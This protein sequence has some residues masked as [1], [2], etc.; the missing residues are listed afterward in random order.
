[1]L[2]VQSLRHPARPI[3]LI[4]A[5]GA[6][7]IHLA[8]IALALSSIQ[9]DVATELGAPA[10]EI[11]VE[12]ASPRLETS[13]LPVGPD[14]Q[15]AAASPANVEQKAAIEQRDLPRAQ[16]VET[17]DPDR[18]VTPNETKKPRDEPK[19][20]AVQAAP[21]AP[22]VAADET[23]IP[24][25]AAAIEAPRSTAPAL[26]T[27]DS[28]RRERQTWQK[29]LAA[30]FNKYKRYPSDRATERAEVVVRFVLDRLGR[31][32]SSRIVHGSGDVAFDDAALGMLQ[33]ANPVPPPPPLVADEGLTFTMPVI[34]YVKG[35]EADASDHNPR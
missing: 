28:A 25:V 20:E 17:D 9:P 11:G 29:E 10:I 34:F 13:D 33:R 35:G 2:A 5:F 27:G 18:A 7:A 19:V 15:A 24:R 21:S 32:V 22:S 12:L 26:G 6:V 31:V 30:H 3:W 16:P 4:A 8:G 23:A 14:T 1:M